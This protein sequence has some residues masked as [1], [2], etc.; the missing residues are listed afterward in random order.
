MALWGRPMDF[1]GWH[2]FD[3]V[4]TE[5][6]FGVILDL[7]DVFLVPRMWFFR[8]QN[9]FRIV[10]ISILDTALQLH[11]NTG[12][13]PKRGHSFTAAQKKQ[14]WLTATQ[15]TEMASE[16]NGQLISI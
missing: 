13:A 16:T 9:P 3:P 11:R 5:G 12:I 14:T 15:K 2:L 7:R 4:V 6:R 8:F 10:I 1:F